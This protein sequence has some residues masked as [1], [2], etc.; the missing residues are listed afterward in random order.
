MS[1][2]PITETVQNALAT[3]DIASRYHPSPSL[4]LCTDVS[5]AYIYNGSLTCTWDLVRIDTSRSLSN[6]LTRESI[7]TISNGRSHRR[8]CAGHARSSLLVN[9]ID[10]SDCGQLSK[11]QCHWTTAIDGERIFYNTFI[12]PINKQS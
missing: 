1:A 4:L 10:T 9:T 12:P 11:A 8:E 6:S 5:E 2:P 3:S 7:P